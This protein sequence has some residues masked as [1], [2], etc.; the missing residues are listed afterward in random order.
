MAYSAKIVYE[1]G[2]TTEEI[3][4]LQQVM[5]CFQE[6]K[7]DNPCIKSLPI[8]PWLISMALD[9]ANLNSP[10]KSVRCIKIQERV[11]E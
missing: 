9:S 10:N 6:A 3:Y 5:R 2:T 4:G 1:D 11:A 8:T 7:V